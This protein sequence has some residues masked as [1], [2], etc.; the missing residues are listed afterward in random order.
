MAAFFLIA[1]KFRPELGFLEN[2]SAVYCL[3]PT[4]LARDRRE[5]WERATCSSVEMK[6]NIERELNSF[7]HGRFPGKK[8]ARVRMLD[9]LPANLFFQS[10]GEGRVKI[11]GQGRSYQ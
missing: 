2:V 7:R 4:P 3:F 6:G 5:T 10:A 9:K 1:V 8:G 11:L